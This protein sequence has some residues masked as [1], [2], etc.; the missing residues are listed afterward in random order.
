[1]FSAA[2]N[3]LRVFLLGAEPGVGELAAFQI[4]HQW[5]AVHVVGTYSPPFGFENDSAENDR[6][7]AAIASAAADLI[8]VGLGAPKQ[9]IWIHR[10]YRQL[11][12]KVVICAGATIDFLA[13]RRRRSPVW[14]RRLGLE[15]LHR[16]CAE[17]RRL[18]RRYTRDACVF[19]QLVW[20][21]WRQ[22]DG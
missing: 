17:P 12:A 6:I 5:P 10:H 3:P 4:A 22:A 20:H 14:M 7:L 2:Q 8:I 19:P 16:L 1:L 13:G 15:W 21:Q 11:P 9:E 18:A